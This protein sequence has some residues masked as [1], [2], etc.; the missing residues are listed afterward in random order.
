MEGQTGQNGIYFNPGVSFISQVNSFVSHINTIECFGIIY[1]FFRFPN[2]F[3][4]LQVSFF[5]QLQETMTI[6]GKWNAKL[7]GGGAKTK[8]I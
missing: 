3:F 8:M 1:I 5:L 4:L 6:Y 2:F 7:G